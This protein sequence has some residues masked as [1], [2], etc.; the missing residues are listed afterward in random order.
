MSD[1]RRTRT[2]TLVGLGVLALLVLL[3]ALLVTG[4]SAPAHNGLTSARP[5]RVTSALTPAATLFG[6]TVT[7]RLQ[8][9]ADTSFVQPA[10]IRVRSNFA[11]YRQVARPIVESRTVG[12][13]EELVWT[14]TLR[15]LGSTCVPHKR[16][17]RFAFGPASVSF[18]IVDRTGPPRSVAVAWPGLLV[19]SRV[20]QVEVAAL[21]PRGEPPWKGDYRALPAVSYRYSPALTATALFGGAALLL[22]A[23]GALLAPLVRR[24][25]E[26]VLVE[27]EPEPLE[28]LTPLEQAL[29][30]LERE[31]RG[32]GE[33][34]PRRQALELV[35]EWLG[36]RDARDLERTAR[37]LAWS[38]AAPPADETRVL[39]QTVRELAD[40]E[41]RTHAG[42]IEEEPDAGLD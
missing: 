25:P 11:P 39:A 15:C 37:R 17:K 5:V 38:K 19:Y 35:S 33:V 13:T 42:G 14:A 31:P 7:A 21:D 36:D 27:P 34:E 32:D 16:G 3:A 26:E 41:T 24:R 18:S 28:W 12:S 6:D 22:G 8:V 9:V 23:A 1:A 20:D 29:T 2:L 30:L 4:R 10:S 40:E